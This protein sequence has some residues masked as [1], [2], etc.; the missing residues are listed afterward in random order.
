MIANAILKVGASDV[1]TRQLDP[2]PHEF[3]RR[4]LLVEAQ[5]TL[6]NIRETY[7]SYP[8]V[9]GERSMNGGAL[10]Q[11]AQLEEQKLEQ[12]VINWE[13]PVPIISG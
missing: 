13:R 6:G 5:K 4:K 7:D 8:T 3:F 1:D 12:D 10:L 11:R 2:R 9:G